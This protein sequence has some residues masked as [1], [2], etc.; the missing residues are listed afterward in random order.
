MAGLREELEL[1]LGNALSSVSQLE[2]A[3]SDATRSFQLGLDQALVLLDGVQ[4]T[5]PDVTPLEQ[6]LQEA[7]AE[8]LPLDID[9]SAV[10]EVTAEIDGI[11]PDPVQLSLF[12]DTDAAVAE[13]D[14][15]TPEPIVV[16][17]EADTSAAEE[18]L[19]SLGQ[20]AQSAAGGIDAA[21][22][23]TAGLGASAGLATGSGDEL[24]GVL[25]GL[26]AGGKAA[27]GGIAAVAGVTTVLFGNAVEAEAA[28]LRFDQ[29]LG[30]FGAQVETVD[31]AGLNVSLD[32]LAVSLGSSDEN[33]R[34]SVSTLFQ[35]AEASGLAGEASAAYAE[36]IAALSARAVAL[37]PALGDVG[38]V[39]LR[40]QTALA[41]GG[42]FA[43]QYGLSLTAAEINAR[44]LADTG[45]T[46]AAE[47]TQVEKAAAGTALALEQVGDISGTVADGVE[48]PT[49]KLKALKEEFGNALEALGAP[50]VAPVFDLLE[51][52]LP[53]GVAFAQV[54][55]DL[56]QLVLPLIIPP[57]EAIG[58]LL[59]IFADQLSPI[60]DELA[61]A[62][63]EVGAA[64]GNALT[65]L[66][67]TI[68]IVAETI[69]E[70][71]L[72]FIPVITFVADVINV[73]AY[74][75]EE[76]G[77]IQ[78]AFLI[79]S[80]VVGF[81]A[82]AITNL[83]S[84]GADAISVNEQIAASAEP[85]A[86][87]TVAAT[88]G[89]TALGEGLSGSTI[90]L[91]AFTDAVQANLDV[92]SQFTLNNQIDDLNRLGVGANELAAA[93]TGG[94]ESTD[95]FIALMIESGEVTGKAAD[96]TTDLKDALKSNRAETLAY[97]RTNLQA[98][99]G[100]D[101][102]LQSFLKEKAAVDLAAKATLDAKVA[103]GE[104]TQS[105]VDQLAA[106]AKLSDGTVDYTKVLGEVGVAQAEY[107]RQ[108]AETARIQEQEA[109]AAFI[110]SGQDVAAF[111]DAILNGT[112]AAEDFAVAGEQFGLTEQQ[113]TDAAA[114]I[115]AAVDGI[116]QSIIG[117]LP[118]VAD[119]FQ[120]VT[121]S[122]SPEQL[123][124][125]LQEQARAA[126]A[127]VGAIELATSL[128]LTN[129][130]GLFTEFG[131]QA[132]TP[133]L[134]DLEA[135]NVAALQEYDALVGGATASFDETVARAEA[136]GIPLASATGA[137]AAA[138]SDSFGIGLGIPEQ[139]TAQTGPSVT[140]AEALGGSVTS[141][142]GAEGTGAGRKF[143]QGLADGLAGIAQAAQS[144]ATQFASGMVTAM[145]K[146]LGIASPSKEGIAIGE[147]FG[148]GIALGLDA[149]TVDVVSAAEA[150]IAGA[151]SAIT[152]ATATVAGTAGSSGSGGATVAPNY[153]VTVNEVAADPLATA[154]LVAF[155]LGQA[156]RR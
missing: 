140:A 115:T 76:L 7:V 96:G 82:E 39:S 95:A 2:R 47:L 31:V 32:E 111:T 141:V 87:A 49:I 106:G 124:A 92:T 55:G 6:A 57:L 61:P 58:G 123:I 154:E 56:A 132:V 84:I 133:F 67:P 143:G 152:G 22:S 36:N 99:E 30:A 8:P 1:D 86:K 64:I 145:N 20:T 3:L 101:E 59:T 44:A 46:T 91:A 139:I 25:G 156:A 90:L 4:V 35:T 75:E 146:A 98:L 5:A 10:D 66:E 15:I 138:A 69:G 142:L 9:T 33:L 102:L 120:D 148:Q 37:N 113:I 62:F 78:G 17:V 125:N 68:L 135:G 121:D 19:S 147:L 11:T 16:P 149:S 80:E 109:A 26:G 21:G 70:L 83:T 105:V 79:V 74:L 28:M 116:T 150:I 73:I 71:A 63:A 27:A 14:A 117:N 144:T 97:I 89:V 81:F 60:I 119:A 104:L 38:D 137:A 43:Q 88:R 128:G 12:A 51:A 131:P 130:A 118:S 134:A 93:L 42:R 29:T 155:T 129:L 45:K 13:I 54:I 107:N 65:A 122:T 48:N 85:L 52:V 24:L 77:I 23:A 108:A 136:L 112:I 18:S 126:A 53:I 110:N 153:N 127:Y 94:A 72:A 50:L 41:R 40:L 114:G 151:S 103:T 34:N 100:N